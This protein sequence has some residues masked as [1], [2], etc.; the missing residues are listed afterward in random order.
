FKAYAT[1]VGSGP[2]PTEQD[3]A[4]GELMRKNGNEFGS[5]TGRARRCGL[6]DLPALKYAISINGVTQLIMMKADV[7]KGF[8]TIKVCTHYMY[9]RQKIDFLPFDIS[10]EFVVPVYAEMKGWSA[11]LTQVRDYNNCPDELKNYVT[12][13]EKELNVPIKILSVGPDRTQTIIR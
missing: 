4:D 2:F 7:L 11:D 1:R 3:N 12:F 8:D 6:I 10:P 13:L 5:T 9:N